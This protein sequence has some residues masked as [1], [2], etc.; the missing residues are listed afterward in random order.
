MANDAQVPT[1][2]RC[3]LTFPSLTT[4]TISLYPNNP[5]LMSDS[6]SRSASGKFS[7]LSRNTTL[8]RR[9]VN[10]QETQPSDVLVE[11]FTAWKHAIKQL[12]AYFEVRGGLGVESSRADDHDRA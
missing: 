4:T 10:P 2:S 3:F 6:L 9:N 5:T 8:V 11:R 7:G 1:C 12:T